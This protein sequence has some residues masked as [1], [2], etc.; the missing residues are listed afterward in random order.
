M[1]YWIRFFTFSLLVLSGQAV[2]G[3]EKGIMVE[4]IGNYQHFLIPTKTTLEFSFEENGRTCG[5]NTQFE[6]IDEQIAYFYYDLLKDEHIISQ[7]KEEDILTNALKQYPTKTLSF[8]TSDT[9]L[10]KL[11]YEKAKYAFA[12]NFQFFNHYVPSQLA[13]EVDGVGFALQDAMKKIDIIAK[14]KRLE[15]I[16][17]VSIEA[18][19]QRINNSYHRQFIRKQEMSQW[20]RDNKTKVTYRVLVTYNLK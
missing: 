15:T 4:V 14:S 12:T 8:E 18:Y 5:P 1:N 20:N 10:F 11:V 9:T 7:I 3:Q 6:T 13:N 16:E 19:P 17:L 2:F